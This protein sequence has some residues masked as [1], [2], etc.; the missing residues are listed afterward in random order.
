MTTDATTDALRPIV[1]LL[2]PPGAGKGTQAR[3]LH[4]K[5]GIPHVASG[6]LLRDHRRR[7]TPLGV[8]ASSYMDRGDLVPDRL[9]IDMVM[10]RLARPDAER[11]ALLDGFPRSLAQAQTMDALLATRHSEVRRALYLEVATE[12]LVERIAGRWLCPSCQATYPSSSSRPPG[13][14]RCQACK[15][16]LYQRPDDRPEV[17][18]NRIEV[19]LRE[20]LPV[21]EHYGRRGLLVR[22]DGNRSIE[23][24][25]ATLYASLGGVVHGHRREHWH[26]YVSDRLS[27]DD[28]RASW[29]GRTLCGRYVDSV[30]TPTRGSEADFHGHPCRHCFQELR[31]HQ[32]P[33]H[34]MPA[35]PL[36]DEAA[37]S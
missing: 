6:D 34:E 13:D 19:Y 33:I 14:G 27:G 12:V 28:D 36:L 29:H 10:E 25:R 8:E 16:Q 17:V 4:D 11:G 2:G 18:Q 26:L 24:V 22:V 7:G 15:D 1:L 20:T 23:E 21:V 9:V 5:L 32:R 35:L 37:G 31:P 30:T 3:F